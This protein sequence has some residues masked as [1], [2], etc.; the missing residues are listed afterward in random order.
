MTNDR[1]IRYMF[2]SQSHILHGDQ[3]AEYRTLLTGQLIAREITAVSSSLRKRREIFHLPRNHALYTSE[4]LRPRVA[5]PMPVS[6]HYSRH[7]HETRKKTRVLRKLASVVGKALTIVHV[8][9]CVPFS[10]LTRHERRECQWVV[11]VHQLR[12]SWQEKF[13]RE[14]KTTRRVEHEYYKS[15][16][17]I[18]FLGKLLDFPDTSVRRCQQ[19]INLDTGI[20]YFLFVTFRGTWINQPAIFIDSSSPVIIYFTLELPVCERV[21]TLNLTCTDDND[22]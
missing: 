16:V 2:N 10:L 14:N 15:R 17:I 21:Y 9:F 7:S 4:C 22:N 5:R 12:F 19:S 3:T 18:L 13:N 6:S 20:L 11:R 8:T 1:L